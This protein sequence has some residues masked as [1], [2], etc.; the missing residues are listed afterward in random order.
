LSEVVGNG[1]VLFDIPAKYTP[2]TNEMPTAGEVEPLIES[3]IH[4]W[5]DEEYY[6]KIGRL[7]LEESLRWR[8]ERL[9]GIYRRFFSGITHQP[10]PPLVPK[11]E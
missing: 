1:G 10:G 9:A 4:L 3:I 5:D 8:P 11:A 6:N 7:A 2:K